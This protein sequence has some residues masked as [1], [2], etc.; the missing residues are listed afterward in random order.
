MIRALSEV[1]KVDLSD[2]ETKIAKTK[3]SGNALF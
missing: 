1:N 2:V 3:D